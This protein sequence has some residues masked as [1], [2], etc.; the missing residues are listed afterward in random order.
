MRIDKR[1]REQAVGYSV[2]AI[3]HIC[4]EVPP[5]EPGSAGEKAA[6]DYLQQHIVEN[7]WADSVTSQP[8]TVAPKAFMGFS[9]IIPVLIVI[10]IILFY[11]LPWAPIL[12]CLAGLAVLI[13]EFLLYWK[14]L[15]PFY[16]KAT[17]HNLIAV[18]KASGEVKRRIIVSGHSDAAYEWRVFNKFGPVVHIG[19]M[20]L[21]IIGVLAAIILSIVSLT[22]SAAAFEANYAWM[23]V[24]MLAFLPG[25]VSL[26]FYSDYKRVVPGANDNLT[27][28]L[29]AV[30][31]LKCL[32]EAGITY[33][34]TEV[35]C[36]V[37]GSEEA[38]L[39]GAKAFAQ[40]YKDKLSENGVQTVFL[41]LETF[42]DIEHMSIY[43][44][45]LSGTVKHDPRMVALLD[46]AAEPFCEKPLPH[47]SVFIGASD[48]AAMTQAGIPGCTLA[49]M[50]PAPARYYH[51]RKDSA[52]NLDP[53]CIALG[54]DI[55]LE[56]VEI[57]N[58]TGI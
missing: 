20:A 52:D 2:G 42:R 24:V 47:A 4:S 48:C 54:L 11:W 19:G 26:Y 46:R 21:S 34:N 14:F 22:L 30:S 58:E 50:D 56:A 40:E 31:I 55:A 43:H 15:D 7:G 13:F 45:D 16:K 6:Q 1:I 5:R 49:S 9:R 3:K 29:A 37:T 33:E 28:S 23:L 57:F 32:K 27:G 12:F 44:R 10:G 38:G 35:V 36:L 53:A 17:S 18:K 25:Y 51:T 39:R 41:G 8:F